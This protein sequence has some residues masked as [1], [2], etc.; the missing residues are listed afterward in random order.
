MDLIE[1]LNNNGIDCKS[2]LFLVYGKAAV[3]KT[4]FLMEMAK[5]AKGKVF[6]IDS[7][8]GFSIERFKQIS[9]GDG[10]DVLITKPKSFD[11]QGKAIADVVDNSELFSFIGVDTIGKYYR[12]A[13][14]EDAKKGNNEIARQMRLLKE[15]SRNKVVV[16]CN[17]VY[18]DFKKNDVEPLGRNYVKKWCDYIIKLD[19]LGEGREINILKPKIVKNE[20]L[21]LNEGFNFS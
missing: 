2:G 6:I 14:K 13:V 8:N 11:K 19:S 21:L 12:F 5:V 3:G 10:E 16:V 20:F 17:Q 7:E 9:N 4:T 15:I 1:F 18:Q